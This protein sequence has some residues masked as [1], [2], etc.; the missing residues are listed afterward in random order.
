MLCSNLDFE[1]TVSADCGCEHIQCLE[2]ECAYF[3]LCMYCANYSY[4]EIRR[5]YYESVENPQNQQAL[6]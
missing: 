5:A 1:C 3:A 6:D 2:D 4:C